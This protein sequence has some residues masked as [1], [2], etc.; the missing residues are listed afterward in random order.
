MSSLQSL[1]PSAVS[2]APALIRPRW[3]TR[4]GLLEIQVEFEDGRWLLEIAGE[5]DLSTV[6]T[7]EQELGIAEAARPERIVVALGELQFIDSSG[8][9]ALLRAERRSRRSGGRLS[10][11]PGGRRI[12]L[13]FR[14]TGTEAQLPFDFTHANH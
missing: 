10:L 3:S 7:L 12:Q 9:H 6:A 8:V 13:A 2:D 11:I 14:L 4:D 1:E 5:L